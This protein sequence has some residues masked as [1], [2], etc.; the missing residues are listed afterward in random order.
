MITKVT[1]KK[2]GEYSIIWSGIDENKIVASIYLCEKQRRLWF[3][4]CC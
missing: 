2:H 4:W 3:E 1:L